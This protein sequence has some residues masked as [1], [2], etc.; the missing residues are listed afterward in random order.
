MV[1]VDES[2][3]DRAV[4]FLE[5]YSAYL[6]VWAIVIDTGLSCVRVALICV[7]YYS[8]QAA[9]DVRLS[10]GNFARKYCTDVGV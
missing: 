5:I 9:L 3:A 10:L 2:L 7:D 1:H 8:Q 6:T 4:D